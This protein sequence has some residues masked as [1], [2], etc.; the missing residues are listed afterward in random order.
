M[1]AGTNLP[2]TRFAVITIAPAALYR[3]SR[4][5]KSGRSRIHIVKYFSSGQVA[6]RAS[7]SFCSN[8]NSSSTN[9]P[10]TG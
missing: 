7:A 3:T 5:G 4:G 6:F 2:A 8:V 10:I 1:N 9:R